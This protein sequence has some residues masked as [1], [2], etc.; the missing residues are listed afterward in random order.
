MS[1]LKEYAPLQ[2][3]AIFPAHCFVS[4]MY[5]L[6]SFL[7]SFRSFYGLSSF[8]SSCLPVLCVC[9]EK[10]FVEPYQYT[11][12]KVLD[13]LKLR[14]AAEEAKTVHGTWA[15]RF[16]L[17]LPL[18]GHFVVVVDRIINLFINSTLTYVSELYREP[19][20]RRIS[21]FGGDFGTDSL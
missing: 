1:S 21:S 8:F 13:F 10:T 19:C 20:N 16:W 2:Y 7:S 15:Q 12:Y 6:S 5:G 4:N 11:S 14:A 3:W 18:S 17:V 9:L